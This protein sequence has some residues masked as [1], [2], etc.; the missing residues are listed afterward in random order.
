MTEL[1][2]L[3]VNPNARTQVYGDLSSSLSGIEPPLWCGLLAA[4]IREH[5]YS[6]RIIDAVTERMLR[7]MKQAGIRW[8]AYGFESASE[9]VREEYSEE[10]IPMATK[11]LS[12]AEVL[13]FRDNAFEKILQ[14]SKVQRNGEREVWLKSGGTY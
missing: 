14:Q 12:A 11:Y 10:T 1:D 8:V 4:F 3:L 7:K 5:G 2:L 6:V 9:R 13:R